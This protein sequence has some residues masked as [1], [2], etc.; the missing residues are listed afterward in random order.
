MIPP[1]AQQGKPLRPGLHSR[2]DTR[3]RPLM[4]P[5]EAGTLAAWAGK[6]SWAPPPLAGSGVFFLESPLLIDS[7]A[8][9]DF[10][11]AYRRFESV[12]SR[13]RRARRRCPHS[14]ARLSQH[15]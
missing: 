8:L 7:P 15:R 6:D 4:R 3:R 9:G 12:D 11:Y 14:L 13:G 5:A 2:A 1:I 10:Q